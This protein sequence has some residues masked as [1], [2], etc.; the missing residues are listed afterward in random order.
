M[1]KLTLEAQLAEAR[2]KIEEQG[3]AWLHLWNQKEELRAEV[4]R[5]RCFQ[6]ED[7]EACPT[8]DDGCQCNADQV[9]EQYKRANEAEAKLKAVVEALRMALDVM[10]DAQQY[11]TRRC[12]KDEPHDHALKRKLEATIPV[13]DAALAVNVKEQQ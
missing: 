6:H 8:W 13:C 7:R 4:E 2:A 5:L 12:L 10:T 1:P 11:H 9:T 3:Q